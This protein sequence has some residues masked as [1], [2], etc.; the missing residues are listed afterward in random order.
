MAFRENLEMRARLHRYPHFSLP[1]YSANHSKFH[2]DKNILYV[3]PFTWGGGEI[4][5]MKRKEHEI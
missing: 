3:S 2:H 4:D 5:Q 1:N